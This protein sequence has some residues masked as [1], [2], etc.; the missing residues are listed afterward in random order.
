MPSPAGANPTP[1]PRPRRTPIATLLALLALGTL[2]QALAPAGA[3]ATINQS[4]G[5]AACAS[6]GGTWSAPLGACLVSD[7]S[8]GW[9]VVRGEIVPVS[10]KAPGSGCVFCNLPNQI[11]DG[12]GK[13]D[14]TPKRDPKA[15]GEGEAKVEKKAGST[16]SRPD[17]KKKMCT[18]LLKTL[19]D[20][21][22]AFDEAEKDLQKETHGE[23][24][25][26]WNVVMNLTSKREKRKTAFLK[27]LKSYNGKGCEAS[28]GPPPPTPVTPE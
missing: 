24:T 14:E 26:D 20:Q 15:K 22:S 16:K 21:K 13:G 10:G 5:A 2:A 19:N 9:V 11:G 6:V 12:A 3:A 1:Q 8:G 18:V 25:L 23:G 28:T 27:T 17:P 7:G 4:T